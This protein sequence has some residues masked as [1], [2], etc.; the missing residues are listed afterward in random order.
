[1]ESLL[2]RVSDAVDHTVNTAGPGYL[3]YIPGGGIYA[4]ALAEFIAASVNRYT[5]MAAVAPPLVEIELVALRWLASLVGYPDTA[6]GAL[7]SGGSLANFTAIAAARAAKLGEAQTDAVVYASQETH[8]SVSKALRLA[9]FRADQYRKIAVDAARRIDLGALDAAIREDLARGRRPF[10]LVLNVGT[11]NTG[12]IDPIEDALAL[13]A[14]H[15]LWTHADGAYGGFFKL[16]PEVA[17]RMRGLERCDS[18]TLDPHKGLFLPYGTGCVL[19][20]DGRWL[21]EAHHEGAAYLRDVSDHA[22]QLN[23]ADITPEL[24]RDFRGLRV[25]LPLKLHGVSAFREA[26]S[27]KLSLARRAYEVLRADDRFEVLGAPELSVVAFRVKGAGDDVQAR[28][29]AAVHRRNRVFLSSTALDGRMTLRLCVLC[30]RT[31]EDR[32]DDALTALREEVSGAL[33]G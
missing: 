12:A 26:L 9:G 19:V 20:R 22:Q 28:L 29:L 30:F 4:A 11:T 14:R 2:A 10:M 27:E 33:A 17:D 13:A 6:Q 15:G 24:S 5:G 3:A 23:F 8:A 21:S 31:H 18:I 7:L 1:M 32:V 16:C 25:W